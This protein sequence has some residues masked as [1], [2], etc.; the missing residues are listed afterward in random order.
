MKQVLTIAAL[1][2]SL[3]CNGQERSELRHSKTKEFKYDFYVQL[4][5]KNVRYKD[6]VLYTWFRAQKVH[7]TQGYSDGYLLNGSFKKYYHSGQL[8]ERGEFKN[9]LRNGEWKSWRETGTLVSILNY[10]A[11]QLHGDYF[12]YN[13]AGKRSKSGSYKKGIEKIDIPKASAKTDDESD[14][15]GFFKRLFKRK[16][17]DAKPSVSEDSER[18]DKN[19]QKEEK[20][21][22]FKRLFSK[23]D[24][25]DKP[26]SK[27]A[28][29]P[30]IKKE[31]KGREEEI[32]DKRPKP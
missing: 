26:K 20:D 28:K 5:D 8:A 11:G 27:E 2:L 30:K 23:K 7:T 24:K 31:K 32:T 6:T 21:P 17:K 16:E 9:G 19:M 18:K 1:I 15:E 13:E 25:K 14:K 12:L 22:F 29:P 10:S 3:C 4:E